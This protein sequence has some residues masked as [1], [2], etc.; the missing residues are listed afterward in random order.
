MT[1]P[2]SILIIAPPSRFSDGLQA[3]VQTLPKIECVI[4]TKVNEMSLESDPAVIIV[5]TTH[6][7]SCDEVQAILESVHCR[8]PEAKTILL[9][10]TLTQTHKLTPLAD[11]VLLKGFST[12]F[13]HEAIIEL[14]PQ[15]TNQLVID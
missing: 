2:L 13:L 14:V 4:R 1:S 12:S 9:V 6:P 11:K 5:D 7:L 3:V 8:F 15:H 10:N